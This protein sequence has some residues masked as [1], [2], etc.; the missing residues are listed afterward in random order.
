MVAYDCNHWYFHLV[1]VPVLEQKGWDSNR[2]YLTRLF[3]RLYVRCVVKQEM[4]AG[5]PTEGVG[6]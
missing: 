6:K 2:E 1:A 3:L 5:S 4:S